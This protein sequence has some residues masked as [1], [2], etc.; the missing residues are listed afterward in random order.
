[1]ALF[2]IWN[3][4]P[5]FI[6]II[7]WANWVFWVMLFHKFRRFDIFVYELFNFNLFL[8]LQWIDIDSDL[9][10]GLPLISKRGP[11]ISQIV[12]KKSLILLKTVLLSLMYLLCLITFEMHSCDT[13]AQ[14]LLVNLALRRWTQQRWLSLACFN[15]ALRVYALECLLYLPS[16]MLCSLVEVRLIIAL[17]IKVEIRLSSRSQGTWLNYFPLLI[18]ISLRIGNCRFYITTRVTVGTLEWVRIAVV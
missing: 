14:L 7:F 10:V 11:L 18:S 17:V 16:L 1:M 3:L 12:S 8:I 13:K 6:I 15:L 5:K 4:R 2:K 9:W